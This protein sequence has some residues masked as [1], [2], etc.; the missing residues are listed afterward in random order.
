MTEPY[1]DFNPYT[2]RNPADFMR[3]YPTTWKN[4]LSLPVRIA[5]RLARYTPLSIPYPIV[6]DVNH[7]VI[8]DLAKAREISKIAGVIIKLTEGVDFLDPAADAYIRTAWDLKIPFGVFHFV[9]RN[10]SGDDQARWFLDNVEQ[11]RS[12]TG[13]RMI[14]DHLDCET[15]DEANNDIG[16][17]RTYKCATTIQQEWKTPGFYMNMNGFNTL[18]FSAAAWLNDFWYWWAHWTSALQPTIPAAIARNRVGLWQNGIAGTHSWITPITGA[19]TVVDHGYDLAGVTELPEPPP[20]DLA[21]RVAALE[22]EVASQALRID[23]AA[24]IANAADSLS[25]GNKASIE[26]LNKNL[27]AQSQDIARLRT[28]VDSLIAAG[29]VQDG[30]IG[31]LTGRIKVIEDKLQAVKERL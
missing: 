6:I 21:K 18:G 17:Y 14:Y 11:Y 15:V 10:L 1:R 26:A 19:K 4:L 24:L 9:R 25:R 7:W 5:P 2:D 27:L 3:P 28:D 22:T 8:V 29:K 12:L 20:D 30:K 16:L 23:S 31:D 13:G